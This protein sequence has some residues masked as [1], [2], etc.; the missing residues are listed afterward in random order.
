[1]NTVL[2]LTE[3]DAMP[4]FSAV[5]KPSARY[6]SVSMV[7]VHVSLAMQSNIEQ[8]MHFKAESWA[9]NS[10]FSKPLQLT[11]KLNLIHK[12]DSIYTVYPFP[13]VT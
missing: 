12:L 9:V 11:H 1:M 8:A 13:Q 10:T 4:T 3:T 7:S 2:T 6:D 5:S